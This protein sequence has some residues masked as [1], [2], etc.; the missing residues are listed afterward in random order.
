[1]MKIISQI[2]HVKKEIGQE[3][4]D[5]E[6]NWLGAIFEG[7][8]LHLRGW[9]KSLLQTLFL[10]LI[11]FLML[12][13]MCICMRREMVRTIAWN[14]RVMGVLAKNHEKDEAIEM[15]APHTPPPPYK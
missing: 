9:V 3:K 1:M 8:G 4:Q 11:V 2:A 10:L 12:W 15:S 14:R 13:L 7:L 5:A 6:Q